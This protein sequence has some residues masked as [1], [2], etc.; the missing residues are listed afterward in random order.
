VP[1]LTDVASP[2]ARGGPTR[3]FGVITSEERL[4]RT[5]A[6]L[7]RNLALVGGIAMLAAQPVLAQNAAAVRGD[8]LSGNRQA[9]G[10]I[11]Q[12]DTVARIVV[13]DGVSYLLRSGI[14]P[15]GLHVGQAVEV[16]FEP[17]GIGAWRRA[18]RITAR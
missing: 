15:S 7:L 12:V 14:D 8:Q 9:S 4:M 11:M 10:M 5:T 18:V 6:N 13:I 2:T 16:N 17:T 1:T 3:R